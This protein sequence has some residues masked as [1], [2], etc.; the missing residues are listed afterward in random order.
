M[1][2]RL[3]EIQEAR[4]PLFQIGDFTLHSG[5][6]SN[7][8]VECDVLTKEDWE[9]LAAMI[10]ERCQFKDVIG[11]PE[12]GLN[13]RDY[14]SLSCTKDDSL[15]TLIVDDVLT[16]GNSMEEARS[17]IKGEVIGHVVFARGKCP[18]W[19]KALWQLDAHA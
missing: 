14:L 11:I 7:W 10:A 1:L 19:I 16:T 3:E 9:C 8:K 2:L 13:L 12:G 17:H 5:E 4:K 6:K 15:P 18:E